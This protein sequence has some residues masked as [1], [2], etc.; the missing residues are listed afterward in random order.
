MTQPDVTESEDGRYIV[1]FVNGVGI[2]LEYRCASVAEAR[3][4]LEVL[5]IDG[6]EPKRRPARPSRVDDRPYRVQLST[7]A[8]AQISSM[9]ED[10]WGG[11]RRA[12]AQRAIDA[13]DV[14]PPSRAM[15]LAAGVRPPTL[16]MRHEAHVVIYQADAAE[17]TL[18]VEDILDIG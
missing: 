16:R 6:S 10:E 8:R 12:I 14:R 3:T 7:N 13:A 15:L 17:R 1:R 9:S 4:L 2:P 11:I 18:T 5:G